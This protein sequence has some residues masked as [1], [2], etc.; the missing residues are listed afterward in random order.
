MKEPAPGTWRRPLAAW[1]MI[2]LIADLAVLLLGLWL[3]V[4]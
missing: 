2:L 3:L 1:E 4:K